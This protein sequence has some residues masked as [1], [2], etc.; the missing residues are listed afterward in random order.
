MTEERQ[1][2][3]FGWGN[4]IFSILSIVVSFI[5]FRNPD[6]SLVAIVIYFGILALLKGIFGL[7][8]RNQIEKWFGP[9][10]SAPSTMILVESIFD[11]IIGV[12]LL[13]N[14]PLGI[15]SLPFIFAIWFIFESILNIQRA[16]AFKA[17]SKFW[18]YFMIV[19]SVIGIILG[20][21]LIFN[22]F[23]SLITVSYLVG[24]Y[25]MFAG[26]RSL[27]LAFIK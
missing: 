23:A 4:L 24:F 5:A 20:V 9:Y 22:P 19:V 13:F 14:V 11:I 8:A 17:V 21:L 16:G 15:A 12:I 1:D 26:I 27:I 3:G 25:F 18:Y 6:A 2:T 10:S 7:F